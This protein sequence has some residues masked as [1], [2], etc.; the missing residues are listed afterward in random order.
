[1]STNRYLRKHHFCAT[2]RREC[3]S[4]C[5]QV[6]LIP[7]EEF[8]N[9]IGNLHLVFPAK[10]VQLCNIGEFAW[11]AIWFGGI[12]L[13]VALKVNSLRYKLRQL[14]DCNLLSRTNIDVAVPYFAQ[15]GN[16][17]TTSCVR[18]SVVSAP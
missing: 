2:E 13:N 18:V 8:C 1:M 6:V 7:S 16:G 3:L 10:I 17:T 9:T 12:E 14:F 15:C 11:S 4:L 5:F